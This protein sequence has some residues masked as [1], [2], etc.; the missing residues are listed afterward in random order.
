MRKGSLRMLRLRLTTILFPVLALVA[1][2]L[3]MYAASALERHTATVAAARAESASY[4]L[5]GMLDQETGLRGFLLT[6][7]DEFLDPFRSGGQDTERAERA[8]R[9]AASADD[10]ILG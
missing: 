3:A 10:R 1:M 8:V 9:A 5:T 2:A 7:R 4:V 6:G